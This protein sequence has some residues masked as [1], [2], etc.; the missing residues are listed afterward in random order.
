MRTLTGDIEPAGLGRT[1]IHEHLAVDWGEMLGR[2]KVP[3]DR[4]E[5]AERM[6]SRMTDLAATGFG[7]MTECTPYGAGRYVDLFH[8]VAQRGPIRIVGSTGFFHE[9]WCPMHPLARAL[10][11][12]GITDLMTREITEGMGGTLVRAGLIKVATGQDRI[13]DLERKVLRAAARARTATGC[14]V[15]V[16]ITNSMAIEV[17][18]VFRAEGVAAEELIISHVGQMADPLAEVDA[19]L[20]RGANFAFDRIGFAHFGTD[21][22]WIGL[23]EHVAR[24]GGLGQLM[25]SHDAGVIAH[26]I[27]LDPPSPPWD[28]FGYIGRA[29]LPR[30]LRETSIT[31]SDV[32]TMVENNPQRVLAFA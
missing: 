9:S 30:L 10:D 12:D 28:D 11:L 32:R 14:P 24:R 23:I 29:F 4:H 26:G 3:F 7:A 5:V 15:L 13:S 22:H 19:L 2:P 27:E 6:I 21:S 20:D 25:L 8:E 17:L 18:D 31:E 16:H 1:L